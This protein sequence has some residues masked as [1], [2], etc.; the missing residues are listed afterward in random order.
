LSSREAKSVNEGKPKALRYVLPALSMT[1]ILI[2]T[3]TGWISLPL[4]QS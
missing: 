1:P 3:F 2:E 4:L